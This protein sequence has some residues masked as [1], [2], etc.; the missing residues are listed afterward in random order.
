MSISI[1]Q[2][3]QVLIN[4]TDSIPANLPPIIEENAASLR[5][6]YPDA[7]Y[8]LWSGNELREVIAENFEP[9]VLQTFDR[10]RPFAYK[11][12]LAR[13]CLLYLYGGLYA[14]LA[15]RAISPLVVPDGIEFVAFK[16]LRFLSPRWTAMSN[17]LIWAK[18]RRREMRLAIDFILENCQLG[19]YGANP[20]YPT[21]PVLFG[22]AVAAAS[23]RLSMA[24]AADDQ[25]IGELRR[26]VPESGGSPICCVAPDNSLV[27]IS[28]KTHG[29]ELSVLGVTGTNNYNSLWQNRQV[30][31]EC[32]ILWQFDDPAICRTVERGSTGIL[33]P[34]GFQGC[35]VYGPYI[36]VEP[37][38]YRLTVSFA[39]GSTIAVV[40]VRITAQMGTVIIHE[41]AQ[42]LAPAD[43]LLQA[44]CEFKADRWLSQ[45]EFTLHFAGDFAGEFRRFRLQRIDGTECRAEHDMA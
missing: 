26:I 42:Q 10:L 37:G 17:G 31:G 29:G 41:H 14:D 19:Y 7:Q 20:L 36:D 44:T 8:R 9:A 38:A 24:A 11:C 4:D 32:R 6:V 25:W 5:A 34:L 33:I 18:P 2:I 12:D 13:L 16:A 23:A 27:A 3:H 39:A 40:A 30:Y 1:G 45:V 15:M 35:A 22:H 43:D 28:A 21:G